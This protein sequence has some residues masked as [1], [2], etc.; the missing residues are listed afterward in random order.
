MR[1]LPPPPSCDCDQPMLMCGDAVTTCLCWLE[2]AQAATG[3][4]I[5]SREQ[6]PAILLSTDTQTHCAGC[7]GVVLPPS[8]TKNTIKCQPASVTPPANGRPFLCGADRATQ[9]P[10]QGPGSC[11]LCV[12]GSTRTGLVHYLHAAALMLGWGGEKRWCFNIN[13]LLID[14]R[15]TFLCKYK[16]KVQS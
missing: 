9:Y 8:S 1:S 12:A 7:R 11:L 2:T 15:I 3:S 5:Q 6:G 16:Y 14:T 4:C 10:A 13:I